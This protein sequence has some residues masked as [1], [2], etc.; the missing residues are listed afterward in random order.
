[1]FAI[2]PLP[3]GMLLCPAPTPSAKASSSPRAPSL[4]KTP[5]LVLTLFS[6]VSDGVQGQNPRRGQ[7]EFCVASRF[8]PLGLLDPG[9]QPPVWKLACHARCFPTTSSELTSKSSP[10]PDV[11]RTGRGFPGLS[12]EPPPTLPFAREKKREKV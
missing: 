7:H 8:V 10:T 12:P 6:P 2:E 4:S 9:S 5:V 1:M 3:R 11:K